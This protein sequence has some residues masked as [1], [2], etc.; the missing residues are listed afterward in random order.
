M[1]KTPERRS[2][3]RTKQRRETQVRIVSVAA[4]GSVLTVVFD[5]P[6]V[7]KGVP[8][9]SVDVVGATPVSAVLA[10]LNTLTLTYSAAIATA[11]SVTIP[12]AEPGIRS[13]VGGFVADTSFPV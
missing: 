5:Q 9:Y 3:E 1:L 4:A 10:S 7:L 12:V 8:Q 11:T 2:Q 6:V 13:K